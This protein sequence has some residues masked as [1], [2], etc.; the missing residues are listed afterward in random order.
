MNDAVSP[1]ARFGRGDVG[2][3]VHFCGI[4]IS[5]RTLS[6]ILLNQDCFYSPHTKRKEKKN[7]Y[8]DGDHENEDV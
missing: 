6:L 8:K 2:L 4:F 1:W 5:K 3:T 7:K